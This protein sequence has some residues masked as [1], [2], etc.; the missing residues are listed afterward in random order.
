MLAGGS[1]DL[2]WLNVTNALLG[3][4]VA[5]CLLAVVGAGIRELWTQRRSRHRPLENPLLTVIPGA[6]FSAENGSM[7]SRPGRE[8]NL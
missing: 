2:T 6:R 4:S 7:V 3:L 8:G 5:A 1:G